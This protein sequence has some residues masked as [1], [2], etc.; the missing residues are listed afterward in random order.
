MQ[1]SSGPTLPPELA[2]ST[3]PAVPWA[4]CFPLWGRLRRDVSVENLVGP[5]KVCAHASLPEH[6]CFLRWL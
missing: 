1:Q 3:D 2:I 6:A 5:A 4:A